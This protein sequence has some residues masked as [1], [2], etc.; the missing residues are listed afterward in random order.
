L[1][2]FKIK[3]EGALCA[4]SEGRLQVNAAFCRRTVLKSTRCAR[5]A[6]RKGKNLS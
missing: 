3:S 5:P 4:P 2:A 6:D 1:I